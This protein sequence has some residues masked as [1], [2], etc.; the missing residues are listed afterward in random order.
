MDDDGTIISNRALGIR[1]KFYNLLNKLLEFR[2]GA[3]TSIKVEPV[4]YTEAELND[5]S[6]VEDDEGEVLQPTQ[7]IETKPKS[8]TD[9]FISAV[10]KVTDTKVQ[11]TEDKAKQQIEKG[12]TNT[13]SRVLKPLPKEETDEQDTIDNT[14]SEPEPDS[15]LAGQSDKVEL[16]EDVQEVVPDEPE[17]EYIP[18]DPYKDL[19]EDPYQRLPLREAMNKV[20]EGEMS[21][22]E[23]QRIQRQ[24]EAYTMIPNPFDESGKTSLKDFMESNTKE[25]VEIKPIE[26]PDSDWILDKNMLKNNCRTSD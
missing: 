1:V 22:R 16:P 20:K 23:F 11:T 26:V 3:P 18:E 17:T 15:K 9:S 24:A 21:A 7:P 8:L 10:G 5:T 6:E 19:P 12:K 4:T 14:V 2:T 13:F 25:D